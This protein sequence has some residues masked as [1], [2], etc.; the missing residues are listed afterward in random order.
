MTH[1]VDVKVL[2]GLNLAGTFVF[3]ISGG[4]AAVRASLR[5]RTRLGLRG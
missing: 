5:L 4:L 1:A 2:L 3:G